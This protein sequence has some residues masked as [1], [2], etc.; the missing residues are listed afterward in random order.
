MAE[1]FDDQRTLPPTPRRLEQARAEGQVA[2]SRELAACATVAAAAIAAWGVGPTAFAACERIVARGLTFG[3][4]ATLS[5]AALTERLGSAAL[6]GLVTLMPLLALIAAAGIG[7]TLAV[8]GWLFAPQAIAPNFD[9][10]SPMRGLGQIFSIHG[11]AELG[12]SL[13]KALVILVAAGVFLWTQR[14]SLAATGAMETRHGLQALGVLTQQA[15]AAFA[16]AL[17]AIAAIDV[18][19]ALWR[20]YRGLRMTPE[21][22]KREMRESEGDP[23]LK[24][25]VRSLMRERARK[26]MM[27]EVPK[28]DVVVTN[29]THYAVALSYREASMGAPRVVAKGQSLVAQ[30]IRELAAAHGVPLLEAPPLA[31]AL[32]AHAEVGDEIP[33]TLYNA[34][35]QVLAYVYQLKRWRPGLGPQPAAPAEFEVPAGMDRVGGAE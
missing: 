9:R 31:R 34:V 28:A 2:R 35:A 6:D 12:K 7:A 19:L 4:S 15:L 30:K 27:A 5:D 22:V 17:A 11:L 13:A 14:D 10:L 16:V 3:P 26:R 18:P 29:P 33:A 32:F 21:E 24:A 25:R 20:H 8:G 1:E 23:Q